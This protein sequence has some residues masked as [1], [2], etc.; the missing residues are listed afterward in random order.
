MRTLS[1]R[2]RNLLF[3]APLAVAP[4]AQAGAEETTLNFAITRNG[5]RIGA[6]TVR[7]QRDGR[8]LVAEITTR[9]KVE[10]ASITLYRFEQRETERWADGKL[11]GLQSI[12][13]DNGTT[14]HVNATRKGDKLSVNADGKVTDYDPAIMP[15]SLWNVQ[16]VKET[17]AFN[18][19]DGS[20]MPVSVVDHG[21]EQ[22]L[23]KGHPM[24]AHHYS[25]KTN[26][27][28]DVWYGEDYRLLKVELRGSDGS[29]ILYQPG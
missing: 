19:K 29:T 10:F 12:T 7:L 13:D 9:I 1:P 6:T 25:I 15:A 28:Q 26:F 21:K 17:M 5:D 3:L 18:S 4:V 27:P 11:V 20:V 24:T 14:H 22:L 23:L 2:W 8:Q 16:L